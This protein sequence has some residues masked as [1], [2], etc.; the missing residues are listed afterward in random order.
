MRLAINPEFVQD[1]T[2]ALEDDRAFYTVEAARDVAA[3]D[4]AYHEQRSGFATHMLSELSRRSEITVPAGDEG[5]AWFYAFVRDRA[6][7]AWHAG[8]WTLLREFATI[9]EQTERERATA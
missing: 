8:D 2:A 5:A 1:F 3:D 6:E 7:L 4:R 9:A